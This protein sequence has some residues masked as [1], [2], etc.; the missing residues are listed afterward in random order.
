MDAFVGKLDLKKLEIKSLCQTEKQK[1]GR[2]SFEDA[3]FLK[4]Y[5]YGYLNG[6]RSSRRLEK[7]SIRNVELQWLLKG[8]QPNYHSIAD[9]RK[10][11]PML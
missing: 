2:A 5:L 8:L 3:L 7:E 4:L 10:S 1:A 6:I 9:F 11:I